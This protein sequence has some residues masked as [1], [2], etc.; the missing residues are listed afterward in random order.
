MARS[1]AA[2]GLA[3]GGRQQR[4]RLLHAD[5][6]A[7][8]RGE[9]YVIFQS[10][11]V[12]FLLEEWAWGHLSAPQ[13]QRH[14]AVSHRDQCMLLRE[15]GVSEERA[16]PEMKKLAKLGSWGRHQ[17]NIHQNLLAL[18]GKPS[19]PAP[20]IVK[21]I[22]MR[23]KPHGESTGSK[24]QGS[25][26][27][28][29]P[30]ELFAWSYQNDKRLFQRLFLGNVDTATRAETWNTLLERGDPRLQTHPMR[31][32]ENW[33]Q[34][35]LPLGLHGD[36]VPVLQIGKPATKSYDT[37]SLQS[38][39]SE[40]STAEIKILLFGLFADSSTDEAMEAVWKKLTWSFYFLSKGIWPTVDENMMPWTAAS[41]SERSLSGKPLAGGLFAVI[42]SLKG[43]LDHNARALGLRHYN[44][45]LMCE[46]DGAHRDVSD[47]TMLY[48][49]FKREAQWPNRQYTEE[50]WRDLYREK[51][52]HPIFLLPGVSHFCLEPEELHVEFFRYRPIHVGVRVAYTC[53]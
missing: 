25:I 26:P 32:E 31:G 4:A 50:E 13:L 37:Y 35:A 5:T 7:A 40:G 21:T 49:N 14:A 6:G 17:R 22:L 15:I 8:G 45:N 27:I 52:L 16:C 10:E 2:A 33:Q 47:P 9:G 29:L 1:A 28:F 18:I 19:M 38:L 39:L 36:G 42:V 43:D 11:A 41:P 34:R 51:Y 44:S 3:I 12:L 46:Y 23:L 24:V 30:H 20:V 48:N 53:F